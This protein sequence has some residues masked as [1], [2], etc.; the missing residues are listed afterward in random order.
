MQVSRVLALSKFVALA[1]F[2]YAESVP[3]SGETAEPPAPAELAQRARLAEELLPAAPATDEAF[4]ATLKAARAAGVPEARLLE[5]EVYRALMHRAKSAD[6]AA[7]A[8]RLEKAAASWPTGDAVL[9][10]SPALAEGLA[11]ALRA[12]HALRSGDAAKFREQGALAVW[13]ATRLADLISEMET[14]RRREALLASPAFA[15]LAKAAAAG[16][17]AAARK[18]FAEAYW[19]DA[20]VSCELAVEKLDAM[21]DARE[22]GAPAAKPVESALPAARG[23]SAFAPARTAGGARAARPSPFSIPPRPGA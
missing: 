15:E 2:A 21:R 11:H 14:R 17:E 22:D 20:P 5:A 1:A 18:V 16:D 8:A 10:D 9:I 23:V 12:Q 3:A 6:C 7:L 19:S 13:R 4:E